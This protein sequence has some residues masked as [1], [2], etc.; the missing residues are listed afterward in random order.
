MNGGMQFPSDVQDERYRD[1]YGPAKPSPMH[2]DEEEW[3]T[4]NWQPAPDEA[5]LTDWLERICELVDKYQPQ[6]MY[7]DGWIGQDA[8]VPYLQKFAAY[9]YNQGAVVCTKCK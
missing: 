8:F 9:Y 3:H 5:Y 4:S 7:F 1:F 6:I 2:W